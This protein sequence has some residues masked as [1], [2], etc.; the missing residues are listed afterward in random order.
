MSLSCL[1]P[2]SDE[3]EASNESVSNAT[4]E[5]E[6]FNENTA[7]TCNLEKLGMTLPCI[8]NLVWPFDHARKCYHAF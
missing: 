7:L 1:F 3:N 6:T 4:I 2:G 8:Y 5:S